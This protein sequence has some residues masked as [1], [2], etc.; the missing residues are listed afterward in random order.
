MIH[1]ADIFHKIS[2]CFSLSL[3]ICGKIFYTLYDTE[4]IGIK[5]DLFFRM[6]QYKCT[7]Q[8]KTQKNYPLVTLFAYG[9]HIICKTIAAVT[10]LYI[11]LYNIDVAHQKCKRGNKI[12]FLLLL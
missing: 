4:M 10:I 8:E 5:R 1:I 12:W 7:A 3:N 2:I 11:I 9:Y 6:Q